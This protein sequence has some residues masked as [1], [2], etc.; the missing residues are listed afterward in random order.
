MKKL[1]LITLVLMLALVGITNAQ[2]AD[3]L[4]ALAEYAP[5]DALFFAAIRTDA[6]FVENLDGLLN[7]L[8]ERAGGVLPE[9]VNAQALLDLVV[10]GLTGGLSFSENVRP[11]LGDSA[12]LVVP[13]V[14][15]LNT[16]A[17]PLVLVAEV[18]DFETAQTFLGNVTSAEVGVLSAYEGEV[19]TDGSVVYTSE[20]SSDPTIILTE[21]VVYY[22][23]VEAALPAMLLPGADARSLNQNDAF[24]AIR[25]NLPAESYNAFVY[26]DAAGIYEDALPLLAPQIEQEMQNQGVPFDMSTLEEIAPL[27]GQQGLGFT[28]VQG[29]AL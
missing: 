27:L 2:S 20:F 4:A 23:D 26:I 21:S 14:D 7:S 10:G 13:T 6:G 19:Q 1:L 5:E 28:I 18:T 25:S 9:G 11:W 12:A 29:R 15:A 8:N 17:G 22:G 3:D 24:T 16:A